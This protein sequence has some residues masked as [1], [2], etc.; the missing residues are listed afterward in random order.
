MPDLITT[1]GSMHV[2]ITRCPVNV[3]NYS[4]SEL[5]IDLAHT[6]VWE[7]GLLHSREEEAAAATC[8]KVTKPRCADCEGT[9][10]TT[11]ATIHSGVA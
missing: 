7:C 5:N 2:V 10:F 8:Q 11:S 1:L 9:H 4:V 6:T 3:Y